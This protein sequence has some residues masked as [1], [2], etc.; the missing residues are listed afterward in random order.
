MTYKSQRKK[1]IKKLFNKNKVVTID[2]LKKTLDTDFS[3][4]PKAS[5]Y[6]I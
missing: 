2:D 6:T 3:T 1:N 5:T 4:T